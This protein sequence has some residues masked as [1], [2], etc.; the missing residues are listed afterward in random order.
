MESTK[1]MHARI[2]RK[3]TADAGFR[4]RLLNNPK[5]TIERELGVDIPASL[6]I[7]VHEESDT[8]AHLVLPPDS[9]LS[10]RELET[11]AGGDN[12]PEGMIEVKKDGRPDTWV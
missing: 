1:E 11:V 4:A 3:A 8:T 10:E 7:E 9:K 6:S 5:E 12:G 2:A